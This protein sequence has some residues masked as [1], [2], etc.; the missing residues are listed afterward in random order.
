MIRTDINKLR[1]RL[2]LLFFAILDLFRVNGNTDEDIWDLYTKK[3]KV[4]LFRQG[5]NY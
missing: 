4:N 5:S 1:N 3:N 2:K